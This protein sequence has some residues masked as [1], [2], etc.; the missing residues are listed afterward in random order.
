MH[1]IISLM[2]SSIHYHHAYLINESSWRQ[3]ARFLPINTKRLHICI[4][5]NRSLKIIVFLMH[6]SVIQN[7]N[8]FNNI[9]QVSILKLNIT[10]NGRS[11]T[12][13]T[14]AT[15]CVSATPSSM[16]RFL[17]L[18][19][20][21]LL[22]LGSFPKGVTLGRE[23]VKGQQGAPYVHS[24]QCRVAI[25]GEGAMLTHLGRENPTGLVRGNV[26]R[27]C[28]W[29]AAQVGLLPGDKIALRG[30]S[31]E[32]LVRCLGARPGPPSQP[33]MS[34]AGVKEPPAHQQLQREGAHEP[35]GNLCRGVKRGHDSGA[36]AFTITPANVAEVVHDSRSQKWG[37]IGYESRMA[38]WVLQLPP[39]QLG[40]QGSLLLHRSHK[41]MPQHLNRALLLLK[42]NQTQV[43]YANFSQAN[44]EQ[45]CKRGGTQW[46]C[47]SPHHRVHAV[48]PWA[49][50]VCKPHLCSQ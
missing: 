9:G 16:V 5:A 45:L 14:M 49:C 28:G 19:G 34:S 47:N 6:T 50:G 33:P 26:R 24:V 29:E 7:L 15:T 23:D 38:R 8:A 36:W 40:P 41:H 46:L 2:S 31:G 17:Q 35:G 48:V 30:Q 27:A 13:R 32:C 11:H 44:L 21:K 10:R 39:H 37:G 25:A 1:Q 18:P 42:P 12:A 22:W 43:I 20:G 3:I 4:V